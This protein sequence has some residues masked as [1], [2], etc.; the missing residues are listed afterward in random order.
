VV[1]EHRLRIP[2]RFTV[3]PTGP[4]EFRMH[5]LTY[6]LALR[7]SEDGVLARLIPLL[8]GE[9][10][11]NDIVSELQGFSA[12]S[13]RQT[14][15]YLLEVGA[16]EW[17]EEVDIAALS[18][19]EVER[20]RSQIAFLSH[21]VAPVDVPLSNSW[22]ATPRTAL[23]YQARIKEAHVVVVGLGRIGSQL[24]RSLAL[25]GVGKVTGVDSQP[26]NDADVHSDAWFT[27]DDRGVSRSE[28]TGQLLRTTIPDVE[29]VA[30]SEPTGADGL[31]GLLMSSELAV[32]CP[33]DFNPSEYEAFNHAAL[34]AKTPW[35]S[36]RLSG[37]EF[38]IGPTVIPFETCCFKC[39]DLRQK[40]NLQD[41]D[42]Y[43]IVENFLSHHRLNAEVPAFTPGANLLA[44]EVLKAIT[45][46]MAP[47]TC[48][49]LYSL[50]LLTMVSRLHPVL[51]IPRCPACGRGAQPRPTVHAWQQAE[52]NAVP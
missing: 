19:A 50:D 18:S 44:L 14:L 48:D 9:R 52:V 21:F 1:Q 24:V 4:A 12:D 29:Y 51:K 46:F 36:A 35:T 27:S 37:F 47:A 3:V 15:D 43:L 45:W 22:A 25:C 13:V 6:S 16:L 28:A 32:L 23:E 10:A 40:S 5:S 39:F 31:Q 49:H 2:H 11:V 38:N 26:V 30:A 41:L 7:D 33:D 42:E 17:V 20:L 34:A 8:N